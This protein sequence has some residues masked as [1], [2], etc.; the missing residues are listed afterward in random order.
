MA[1]PAVRHRSLLFG[2]LEAVLVASLGLAVLVLWRSDTDAKRVVSREERGLAFLRTLVA[3]QVEFHAKGAR[4][5]DGDGKPEFATLDELVAA[6]LVAGTLLRD[7]VATYLESDGYRVEVLLP[8]GEMPNRRKAWARSSEHVD[9]RLA[10]VTF[11]VVGLP[12]AK[13]PRVLRGF[14][15]DGSGYGYA[16]DGVYSPDRDPSVPPPLF[17]LREGEKGEN[18]GHDGGPQWR[19]FEAPAGVNIE[20]PHK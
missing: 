6:G 12:L 8:S 1:E 9:S 5:V 7:D 14:Y 10:A 4:D 15:L 2:P 19:P 17:E 20:L 13:G 16:V 18:G 3:A 11:A